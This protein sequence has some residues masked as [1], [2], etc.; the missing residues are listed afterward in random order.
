[1]LSVIP[2]LV[3]Q[4]L[5]LLPRARCRP[6]ERPPSQSEHSVERSLPS[7]SK[8]GGSGREHTFDIRS[9]GLHEQWFGPFIEC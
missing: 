5:W 9:T 2:V 8:G 7:L 6:L 3:N 1:M 4:Q